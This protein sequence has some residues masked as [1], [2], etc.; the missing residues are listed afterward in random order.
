MKKI[1]VKFLA[2]LLAMLLP[3]TGLAAN[4]EDFRKQNMEAGK[5]TK[6]QITFD[7]NPVLSTMIGMEEDVIGDIAKVLSIT[8]LQKDSLNGKLSLGLSG[9]DILSFIV[10][11]EDSGNLYTNVP[12]L[13]NIT[14]LI[15]GV[16]ANANLMMG[17]MDFKNAFTF[18]SI[19]N[20]ASTGDAGVDAVVKSIL[21]KA[22]VTD[23]AVND[24]RFDSAAKTVVLHTTN[25]DIIAI[26]QTDY[27]KNLVKQ[28]ESSGTNLSKVIEIY[29]KGAVAIDGNLK[30]YFA[31]DGTLVAMEGPV[32]IKTDNEKIAEIEGKEFDA[33]TSE[34]M[35][36]LNG[37]VSY[38]K[39]TDAVEKHTANITMLDNKDEGLT[40]D[41]VADVDKDNYKFDAKL[42]IKKKDGEQA[43]ITLT[44]F[45]TWE[46]NNAKGQL[47]FSETA[48]GGEQSFTIDSVQSLANDALTSSFSIS[49]KIAGED[50]YIGKINL[51]ESYLD[52][53]SV[54]LDFSTEGAIDVST[55]DQA[56]QAE[57]SRRVAMPAQVLVMSLIDKLPASAQRLFTSLLGGGQ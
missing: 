28:G 19:M 38:F 44:G 6:V 50:L 49:T 20:P 42:N 5:A 57:L 3:L 23:E 17:K 13:D 55:L 36:E 43:P 56:T 30:Y 21:A 34:K 46:G 14:L 51:E 29:E 40:L 10:K 7:T 18:D 15:P 16:V 11:V 24:N 9:E 26:M 48:S 31:E 32:N 12:E 37:T 47:V 4:V 27:F 35:L 52:P 41:V 8:L 2:L 53:A 54:N 25:E 45:N 22:V 1:Q 39:K 33:S